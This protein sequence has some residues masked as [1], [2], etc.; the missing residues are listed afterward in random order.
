M[1]ELR[2]AVTAPRAWDATHYERNPCMNRPKAST[3]LFGT[4][5]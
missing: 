1:S 2:D 3:N 5:P 4:R